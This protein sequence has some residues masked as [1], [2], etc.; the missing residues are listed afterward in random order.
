MTVLSLYICTIPAKI[1]DNLVVSLFHSTSLLLYAITLS[2]ISLYVDWLCKKPKGHAAPFG[3]SDELKNPFWDKRIANCLRETTKASVLYRS[4]VETDERVLLLTVS[5]V[6]ISLE[7]LL[8]SFWPNVC[9]QSLLFFTC[10]RCSP[11]SKLAS[12]ISRMTFLTFFLSL[13]LGTCSVI[14]SKTRQNSSS[15]AAVC[16]FPFPLEAPS[17]RSIDVPMYQS[18]RRSLYSQFESSLPFLFS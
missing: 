4:A 7:S 2:S 17:A 3:T 12:E 16:F 18:A 5:F 14:F 1:I 9:L 11:A 6:R 13:L 8:S 15:L 10:R